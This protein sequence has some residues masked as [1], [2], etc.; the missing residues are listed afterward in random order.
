MVDGIDYGT[1]INGV[2]NLWRIHAGGSR[3]TFA[4]QPARLLR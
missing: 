1:H 4:R 2:P 3:T